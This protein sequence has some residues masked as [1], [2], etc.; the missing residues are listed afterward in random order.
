MEKVNLAY[1]RG[2]LEAK[3]PKKNFKA[4]LVADK[5]KNISDVTEVQIVLDALSNPIGTKPL[6]VLSKG[7]ENVVIITS[8]HTRA[9]PSLITMPLLL[10]EVRKGNPQANITILIATGLHR[11]MTQTELK[12]RFGEEIF[13]NETII[14]HTAF[15]KSLFINL[16]PLPSGSKCELNKLAIETDLL[17]AEGFIEPHFF[18]GY[19]GGRKSVFP[20]VA[21]QECVN[22]NHSAD[23]I[24]HP[25]A[26]TGILDGN[27]IH[28]DMIQA[29]RMANLAFI[30]NVLMDEDKKIVAA[31]CGD[32]DQAHR[33]GAASLVERCGVDRVNADIVITTNAGYPLDQNLYQCPKGL[34]T[35]LACANE[36]AVII[37]A[38]ACS[39]GLGGEQFG[40][41]ML[42][43]PPK[44]LLERI[45][46]IPP[47]QTISEQWCAQRFSD[48]LCKYTIILV[49]E[50]LEQ[51]VVEQMNFIYSD[52]IEDA[53]SI[54]LAKKGQDAGIIV[55]PDGVGVIVRRP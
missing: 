11:G 51:K 17:V 46:S 54:A 7:K 38:A 55:I 43:A 40:E 37:I 8:D 23:A 31:Y 34:D 27:P 13:N 25:K 26:A 10:A 4:I 28:E 32:V 42:S 12:E 3:I 49:S 1:G 39:D 24:K 44:Q 14:N 18:A 20:G 19:S 6:S 36:D 21:S 30:C 47:E 9:L 5:D 35:A 48:A 15:D 53:I 45:L 52:S 2:F 50:G 16:G 22:I 41:L 33:K 29:A